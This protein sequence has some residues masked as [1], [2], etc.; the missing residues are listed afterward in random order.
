MWWRNNEEQLSKI[1]EVC[2]IAIEEQSIRENDETYGDDDY[3]DGIAVGSS[4]IARSILK[5]L[6][7]KEMV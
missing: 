2:K 6:E 5:I 4:K 7:Y 3:G 1:L